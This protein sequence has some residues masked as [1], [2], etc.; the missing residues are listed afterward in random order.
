MKGNNILGNIIRINDYIHV[1]H[2]L[3]WLHKLNNFSRKSTSIII[4]IKSMC[5]WN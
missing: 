4:E 1:F 3:K 2:I 5:E